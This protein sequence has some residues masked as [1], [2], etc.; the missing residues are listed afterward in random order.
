MW[1][2]HLKYIICIILIIN[3]GQ[4]P[5][6][7]NSRLQQTFNHNLYFIAYIMYN[8]LGNII[9]SKYL[10]TVSNKCLGAVKARKIRVGV[11]NKG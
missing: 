5:I 3:I 9:N 8:F 10:R 11:R 2:L 1:V 7:S 4:L 6:Q